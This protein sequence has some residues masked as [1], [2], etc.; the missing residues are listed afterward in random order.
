MKTVTMTELNQ[1]TSA[2]TRE[3]TEGG[4]T[5][6]V[7]NHG[8][9]VLRLVPEKPASDD[10]LQRLIDAGLA[11]P[12]RDPGAFDPAGEPVPTSR[13]LDELL[14]ET[15]ADWSD[16]PR[17]RWSDAPGKGTFHGGSES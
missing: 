16:L 8:K 3:V 15:R 17:E 14:E 4:E 6:R 12:A 13:P 10:P 9:T 7:T 5:V 1:R 2:I 11:T